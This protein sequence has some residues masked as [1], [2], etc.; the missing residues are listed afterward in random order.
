MYP[1]VYISSYLSLDLGVGGDSSRRAQHHPP[2]HILPLHTPHQ[3]SQLIPSHPQIQ[4]LPEC[5]HTCTT[6][7]THTYTHTHSLT[8]S[9]SLPPSL[10]L[11]HS[12]THTHTH[13]HSHLSLTHSL[14]LPPSLPPSHSL[15]HSLTHTHTHTHSPVMIVLRFDLN[16]TNSALSP[17]LICPLSSLPVTTVPRPPMEN[18]LSTGKRNG[19]SS[20]RTGSG[21]QSSTAC[22]N[23]LIDSSPI[24]GLRP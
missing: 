5:L 2:L 24:S 10:S 18:V 4:L 20:S 21:I 12:H 17:F 14:S 11:T 8:L 22:S 16:P 7:H 15:T 19:L 9:L 3:H 23:F 6:P 1:Y 13:S